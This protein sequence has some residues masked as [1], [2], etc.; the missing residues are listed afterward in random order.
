MITEEDP[1]KATNRINLDVNCHLTMKK[2]AKTNQNSASFNFLISH[3]TIYTYF[4]H[5]ENHCLK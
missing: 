2:K 5:N 3:G 1:F 4:S